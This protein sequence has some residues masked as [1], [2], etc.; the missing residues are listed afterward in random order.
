MMIP[1]QP[2]VFT[3]N[4]FDGLFKDMGDIFD[5]YKTSVPY[6]VLQTTDKD[7]NILSTEIEVAL[8]GYDKG[9]IKISVIGDEL[10]I[11][12]DK[13]GDQTRNGNYIHKGISNR[14]IQLKFK[15]AG[16]Y[17]K[18]GIKTTFKNGL[19]CILIPVSKE[20]TTLIDIE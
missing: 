12:V 14:S 18:K 8:A 16:I 6:N 17:N 9:D 10:Q 7:G 13:T 1:R 3:P 19:L 5:T 20:E 15:L 2:T 4:I 11:N